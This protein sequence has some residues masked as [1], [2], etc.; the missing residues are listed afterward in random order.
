MH[1]YEV[2]LAIALA[3]SYIPG[4]ARSFWKLI[5]LL[6]AIVAFLF[7]LWLICLLLQ[8]VVQKLRRK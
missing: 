5:G 3:P 8:W 1:V 2:L 4:G 6:V 7:A